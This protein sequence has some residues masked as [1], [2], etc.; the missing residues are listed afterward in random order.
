[1]FFPGF[2]HKNILQGSGNEVVTLVLI[3]LFCF[4]LP[5]FASCVLST[6][7]IF[8]TRRN[9]LNKVDHLREEIN[10][11]KSVVSIEHQRSNNENISRS[12][13]IEVAESEIIPSH[14]LP[15]FPECSNT[16]RSEIRSADDCQTNP[17]N[18]FQNN[19]ENVEM[20]PDEPILE[21]LNKNEFK[22]NIP[23]QLNSESVLSSDL[24]SVC[25]LS[26]NNR[27]GDTDV[28]SNKVDQR[29]V[30]E[31]IGKKAETITNDFGMNMTTIPHLLQNIDQDDV[32]EI[33]NF[34]SETEKKNKAQIHAAK[35][36]LLINLVLGFLFIIS[37]CSIMMFTSST[38]G[39]FCAI[40]LNFMK[41]LLP[42]STTIA[43]FGTI[44]FVI[45]Q[46]W[47]YLRR[48][49]VFCQPWKK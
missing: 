20:S 22:Q 11:P 17:E 14:K 33:D 48:S 2:P 27:N 7:L 10:E 19:P 46:Y 28:V 15:H 30:D 1:M 9:F 32:S 41:A 38:R 44:Q 12:V 25:I 45:L 42:T 21:A 35:R 18:N 36:C 34:D 39:Y 49:N 26:P 29:N 5:V 3:T 24:I 16:T 4:L 31:D 37:F 6:K 47:Q 8:F 13:R 40:V 43:N 23:K